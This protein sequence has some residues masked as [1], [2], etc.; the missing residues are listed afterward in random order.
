MTYDQN[1]LTGVIGKIKS[2]T[3]YTCPQHRTRDTDLTALI[4]KE[5]S[6]EA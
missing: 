4:Q 1:Y 6:K 5:I 2:I 3:K